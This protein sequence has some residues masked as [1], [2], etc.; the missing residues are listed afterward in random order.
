[1]PVDYPSTLLFT[2]NVS[3][4]VGCLRKRRDYEKNKKLMRHTQIQHFMKWNL[5]LKSEVY[6]GIKRR[7]I[8]SIKRAPGMHIHDLF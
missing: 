6:M 1:M 4:I 5:M 2:L 8:N 3:Y 7:L